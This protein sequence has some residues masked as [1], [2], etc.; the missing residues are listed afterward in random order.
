M[1][2]INLSPDSSVSSKIVTNIKNTMSDHHSAEKAFN[3][4][5]HDFRADTLP[6]VAENWGELFNEEKEQ[7]TCMNKFFCGLHFVVGLADSA[8][9]ALK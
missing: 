1:T 9:E 3:E 8:E 4:L 2:M 5:L 7:L 6:S